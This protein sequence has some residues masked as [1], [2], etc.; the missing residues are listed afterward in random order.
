MR[1]SEYTANQAL[2]P[3]VERVE[4][5]ERASVAYRGARDQMSLVCRAAWVLVVFT[6]ACA[7][8][9]SYL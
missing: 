7:I 3:R 1:E 6:S 4:R 8:I 5:R 9:G 2:A